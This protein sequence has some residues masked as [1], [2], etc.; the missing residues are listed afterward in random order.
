MSGGRATIYWDTCIWLAWL[1]NEKRDPA[2]MGGIQQCVERFEKGEILIATSVLTLPEMLDLQNKLSAL[3]LRKF[4]LFFR[5]SDLIRIA[6]D[7][8]VAEIAQRIRDYYF[9]E[10]QKDGL[11]T[12]EL[13]DALHLAS[14]IHYNVDEFITFDERDSKRPSRAKRGILPL[15]GNVAGH[16]LSIKKPSVIGQMPLQLVQ[17]ADQMSVNARD[18]NGPSE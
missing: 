15:D 7:M 14:A 13:G 10:F 16:K 2:E 8:R 6:T 5:R 17:P 4:Q 12:L 18:K 9:L 11:P 3:N 1:K